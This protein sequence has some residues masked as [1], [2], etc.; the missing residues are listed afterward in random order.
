MLGTPQA[1]AWGSFAAAL[2]PTRKNH[3]PKTFLEKAMH[4]LQE[5]TS[6]FNFAS[7]TTLRIV[8]NDGETKN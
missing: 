3:K 2:Q 6:S 5:E 1:G 8:I 7:V 4:F